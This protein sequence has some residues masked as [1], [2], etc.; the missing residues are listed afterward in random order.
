MLQQS[1]F[2]ETRAP[3]RVTAGY[4]VTFQAWWNIYP[5]KIGKIRAEKNYIAAVKS[6][7]KREQLSK[8]DATRKLL[9]AA[10]S[11]AKSAGETDPQYIPHPATWLAQGR[12]D[13]EPDL[14]PPRLE[15]SRRPHCEICK[16][17]DNI[18]I[19]N[20]RWS[21]R[22]LDHTEAEARSWCRSTKSGPL[23]IAVCCSCR[24]Q[25]GK[26]HYIAGSHTL[27]SEALES[28]RAG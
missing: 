10:Q 28:W 5:R 6:I 14:P 18:E 20:P 16:N 11:Y 4:E 3:K 21:V 23:I 27:A 2:D 17:V 24:K 9:E 26:F 22:Q 19:V 15:P 25:A 7:K 8:A 12:W 13:D 1:F